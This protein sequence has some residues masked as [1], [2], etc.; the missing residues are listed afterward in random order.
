MLTLK[1]KIN[2]KT[3]FVRQKQK[4]SEKT[5]NLENAIKTEVLYYKRKYK[6]KAYW[7][8]KA[9]NVKTKKKYEMNENPIN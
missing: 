7:K 4:K 6:Y 2:R 9:L 3:F 1:N 8:I 5:T